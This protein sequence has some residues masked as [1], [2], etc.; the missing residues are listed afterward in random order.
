M[1]TESLKVEDSLED[2]L[3]KWTDR[4]L[5]PE[6]PACKAGDLPLIYWPMDI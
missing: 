2:V 1:E 4:D 6:P 5:N 3:D